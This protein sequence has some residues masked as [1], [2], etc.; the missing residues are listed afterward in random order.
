M[1]TCLLLL[2]EQGGAL[3]IVFG[4]CCI[5][6]LAHVVSIRDCDEETLA[7]ITRF[8]LGV[9]Q[10]CKAMVRACVCVVTRYCIVATTA[11]L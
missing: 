11:V 4:H 2:C 10:M 6:P 3:P 8:K 7:E 1:L 9:E 5:V